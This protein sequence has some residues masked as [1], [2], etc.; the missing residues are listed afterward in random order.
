MI[1]NFELVLS[2]EPSHLR[3]GQVAVFYNYSTVSRSSGM[4]LELLRTCYNNL[5]LLFFNIVLIRKVGI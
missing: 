3:I 2:E 1:R 4:S 5:L